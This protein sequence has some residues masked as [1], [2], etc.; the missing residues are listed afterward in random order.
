[1]K[2]D[3]NGVGNGTSLTAY[4]QLRITHLLSLAP[5]GGRVGPVRSGYTDRA[6]VQAAERHELWCIQDLRCEGIPPG[7]RLRT[8]IATNLPP[9][10]TQTSKV[11]ILPD[12]CPFV[13]ILRLRN[14]WTR[15]IQGFTASSETT[16]PASDM[17]SSSERHDR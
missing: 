16:S 9:D 14:A 15:R 5:P 1:M 10:E 17:S 6:L 4:L 12:E 11:P 3:R 7:A 2:S 8:R 13:Q